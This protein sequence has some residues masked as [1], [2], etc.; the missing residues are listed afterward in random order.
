MTLNRFSLAVVVLFLHS[1]IATAETHVLPELETAPDNIKFAELA[2]HFVGRVPDG[3]S[4]PLCPAFMQQ[5][6]DGKID[7]IKPVLET[8]DSTVPELSKYNRCK[9]QQF[10]N[11]QAGGWSP[12]DKYL[13]P[14]GWSAWAKIR[15]SDILTIPWNLRYRSVV[16]D[17]GHRNFK[18]FRLPNLK[19]TGGAEIEVIYGEV[20]PNLDKT[21]NNY[22]RFSAPGERYASGY[23]IIETK[24]CYAK[25]R[26][27]WVGHSIFKKPSYHTI[28]RYKHEYYVLKFYPADASPWIIDLE[29]IVHRKERMEKWLPCRWSGDIK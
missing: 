27:N 24:Q 4:A 25:W 13:I 10:W 28:V 1:T 9:D 5:L 14:G 3:F 7:F 6:K 18:L 22:L 26:D 11:V 23:W 19:K 17:I 29:R 15:T 2:R 21:N 8:D 20:D 12:A 16:P